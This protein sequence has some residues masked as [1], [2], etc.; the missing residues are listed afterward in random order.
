M[1]IIVKN[2]Q[3]ES[4]CLGTGGFGRGGGVRGRW[5]RALYSFFPGTFALSEEHSGTKALKDSA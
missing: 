4:Y 2:Y 3:G 1:G 5:E